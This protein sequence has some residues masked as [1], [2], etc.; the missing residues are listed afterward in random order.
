[1]KKIHSSL[2][3]LFQALGVVVYCSLVT[4]MLWA[5]EKVSMSPPKFFGAVVILILLVFSAA[6]TGSIVFGYPAYLFLKTKKIK[7]A[8]SI[9]AFTLLYCLGFIIIAVVLTVI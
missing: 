2:I 5:L 7:Q 6:I 8:L 9:L 4:G 1:M 3:G